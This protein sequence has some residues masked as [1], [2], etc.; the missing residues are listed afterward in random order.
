MATDSAERTRHALGEALKEELATTPLNRV[1]V[2]GLTTRTGLT[3]QAFYYHFADVYD[4]AIWTFM[5]E[6]AA[7]VMAMASYEHWTQGLEL[8]M[9]WMVEMRLQVEQAFAAISHADLERFLFEQLREMM[10]VV[11][12]ELEEAEGAHLSPTDRDFI[13]DHYTLSVL[14]HLLHWYSGGMQEAPAELVPRIESI[15][16]GSVR[17]SLRRFAPLSDDAARCA[18]DT[19]P[20]S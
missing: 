15:L 6:I 13:I 1:T 9:D 20:R 4:L 14:G 19:R 8:L 11:L 17:A 5:E 12:G 10:T 2:R 3:R 18:R 7:H 16:A